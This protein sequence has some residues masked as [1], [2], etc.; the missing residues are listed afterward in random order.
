M[1]KNFERDLAVYD[2][3]LTLHKKGAHAY[4]ISWLAERMQG[5]YEKVCDQ[6]ANR[7][8]ALRAIKKL[9]KG[10]NEAIAAMC[11]VEED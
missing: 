4:A 7:G 11:D 6:S 1:A 2:A 8:A 10:E 9:N 3:L 5:S